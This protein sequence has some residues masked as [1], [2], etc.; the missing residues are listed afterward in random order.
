M[1]LNPDPWSQIPDPPTAVTARLVSR[2]PLKNMIPFT[3]G[4]LGTGPPLEQVPELAILETGA[5]G[6]G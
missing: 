4:E 3:S 2:A 6:M 5:G 1:H